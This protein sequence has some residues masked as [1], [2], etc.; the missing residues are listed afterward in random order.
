M[1]DLCYKDS[2]IT[3]AMLGGSGRVREGQAQDG[4]FF[5]L[6]WV[7]FVGIPT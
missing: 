7:V 5:C 3:V 2:N 6:F 1:V 4:R